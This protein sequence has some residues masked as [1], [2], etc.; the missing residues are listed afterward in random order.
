MGLFSCWADGVIYLSAFSVLIA[1]AAYVTGF[2]SVLLAA[3]DD[4][5]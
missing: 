2:A 1:G 5:D 4:S 3:A